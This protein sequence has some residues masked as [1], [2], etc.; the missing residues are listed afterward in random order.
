VGSSYALATVLADIER[1]APHAGKNVLV[2]GETGTGKELVARAIHAGSGRPGRLQPVNCATLT[3]ELLQSEL[4]GH[5]KNAFTGA[6]EARPG[7]IESAHNGTLFLDE[8][9]D[10]S[11][12]LQVSLLRFLE[13]GE[14][15]RVGSDVTRKVDVRIIAASNLDFETA[16]QGGRFRKELLSR[17]EGWEIR[18]P[19][20]SDRVEDIPSIAAHFVRSFAGRDVPLDRRLMAALLLYAWPLNVRE[21]KNLVERAVIEAHG[22]APIPLSPSLERH[23]SQQRRRPGAAPRKAGAEGSKKAG[24]KPSRTGLEEILSRL[25]GNVRKLA[26]EL[27]VSR[28]TIYRWCDEYGID[29]SK[30]RRDES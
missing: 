26:E 15:R 13:S 9:G 24:E 17:L 19:K 5:E 16:T 25:K 11:M 23:L 18:L 6:K 28:N 30:S 22:E 1:V 20:L 2:R 4:F 12:E 27:G 3:G 8:I 10:A 14:T 29:L 7:L 21:L